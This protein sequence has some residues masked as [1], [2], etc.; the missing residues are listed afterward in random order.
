MG[1]YSLFRANNLFGLPDQNVGFPILLALFG[2]GSVKNIAIVRNFLEF[3]ICSTDPQAS[4]STRSIFRN[5]ISE[6]WSSS[7]R[8]VL[9]P[10]GLPRI[11]EYPAACL[12]YILPPRSGDLSPVHVDIS[13][14]CRIIGKVASFTIKCLMISLRF[15]GLALVSSV[16]IR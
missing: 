7:I 15:A 10:F 2:T 5:P 3:T 8:A 13:S 6:L 4:T 16:A 9:A 11:A 14:A 1:S 12:W